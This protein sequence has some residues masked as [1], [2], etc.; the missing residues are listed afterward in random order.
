[1]RTE[2]SQAQRLELDAMLGLEVTNSDAGW[3]WFSLNG[4]GRANLTFPTFGE[5][6]RVTQLRTKTLMGALTLADK[7]KIE[8]YARALAQ[9]LRRA[10]R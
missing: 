10:H 6:S 5:P 8:R 9:A 2:L 4:S 1:M 3:C 7:L